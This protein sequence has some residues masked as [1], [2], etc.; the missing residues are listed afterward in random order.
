MST[1][2]SASSSSY[3]T[4]SYTSGLTDIDTAA[5]VQDAYDAKMDQADVIDAKI[6]DIDL[7]IAA[8]QELQDLLG[9]LE[10]AA[11]ALSADAELASTRDDVWVSKTAY[12]S[13]S[14]GSVTASD[15]VGVLVDDTATTGTYELEVSQIATAHK[16][17]GDVA[18]SASDAAGVAGDLS[19][20]LGDG[21]SVDISVDADMS[22]DDIAD[23]INKQKSTSG[24]SASVLQISDTQFMLVLSAADTGE[25]INFST[26][27]AD[28]SVAQSLGLIGDDG[29]YSN[30]LIA[31]QPAIFSVDG[32]EVTR[33]SNTV[34]DVISGVTL[35]LYDAE[36]GTKIS[37]EVDDDASSAYDAIETFVDAYNDF[38]SFVLTNQAYT[39]GSGADEDAV[40]FGDN[41]L[42]S[43]S[44]DVYDALGFRSDSSLFQSLSSIGISYD[45]S[46][47]L[48]ID[49]DTLENALVSD[50]DTV[51]SLFS[52]QADTSS[53]DLLVYDAD[54]SFS[55][56]FT[57]NIT[58]NDDGSLASADVDGD[59]SLFTV[60]GNKIT[61][62]KGSIYEG[63]TLYF[64]GSTSESVDV[65]I[66]PGLAYG[67]K[68]SIDDYTNTSDG[69]LSDRIDRLEQQTDDLEDEVS[70]ITQDADDYAAKLIDRYS[71]LETK[72]YQLELLRDQLQAL[73]GNND[74]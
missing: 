15:V 44:R 42:S 22:L 74:D 13:S 47:Y 24:V 40:L 61:G 2:N 55:G 23:E 46:N 58:V 73:W 6:D 52:L 4:S 50:F 34:D 35:Y 38:R 7:Q 66:T 69:F 30:E 48:V 33:N 45:D 26:A 28:T 65:T 43:V 36:E 72:M 59:D 3:V 5:L 37:L 12:L 54:G 63:V 70:D 10:D 20:A 53:D 60:S 14:D 17:A 31:A 71:V 51:S 8:Y 32:V 57:I 39:A 64:G 62:A 56:N 11:D 68:N 49:S 19:L 18:T 1:V 29:S 27:G 21:D 9:A 25:E 67:L 16:I 41:L